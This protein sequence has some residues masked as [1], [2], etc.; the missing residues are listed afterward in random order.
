MAAN[1]QHMGFWARAL[2]PALAATWTA[3]QRQLRRRFAGP[4][5]PPERPGRP[6]AGQTAS[7]GRSQA[8]ELRERA[9]RNLV[10]VMK[11]EDIEA[12]MRIQLLQDL[13]DLGGEEFALRLQPVAGAPE[14]DVE[15]R[16]EAAEHLG[17]YSPDEGSR[18]LEAIATD[19]T[20]DDQSRLD[21]ASAL[22]DRS[23]RPAGLALMRLV[24]DDSA[25][26]YVRHGAASMLRC[27]DRTSAAVAFG[28]LADSPLISP[29]LRIIC[30]EQ[31]AADDPVGAVSALRR[32]TVGVESIMDYHLG[33]DAAEAV[34][35]ICPD[36]GVEVFSALATDSSFPWH[37]RIEA[38]YRL[39]RLG[40]G[41]G[42]DLL[43]D[44]ARADE[45]DDALGLAALDRLLRLET[46]TGAFEGDE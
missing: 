19:P 3:L 1:V 39:G 14:V 18:A 8:S 2:G 36:S 34:H 11:N 29:R 5:E 22:V 41:D 28:F 7:D 46:E 13:V 23:D 33:I 40:V 21:A 20:V 44:F 42:F 38:A 45:L 35:G 10:G 31:L 24:T 9:V 27:A 25:S 4:A 30:A 26:E 32:L 43:S 16:L 37:G 17:R 15:V 6:P 12:D